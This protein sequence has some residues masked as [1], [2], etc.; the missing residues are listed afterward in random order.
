MIASIELQVIS[1]IL[2]SDSSEDVNT[3]CEFDSSYYS[4]FREHIDYI[5]DH[6]QKY[7]EIPDV[8][9]F[10]AKF[11]DVNLVTVSEPLT[12]LCREMRKNKQHIILLETFNKLK[13]LGSGDV[14]DAWKYIEYQCDKVNQLDDT[15][16]MDIVKD[17]KIRSKEIVEFSKQSRIPT[18]FPE[19]DK[20]MYGGLSTVEELLLIVARTNSGKA[21]PLWSK[22]LTP[23]GWIQMGDIKI[24]D[25]V[26][27][28]NNDNGKVI[29]IFPQGVKDYYRVNFD[30]GTSVECCDDHLWEV[31][32]SNRRMRDYRYYENY[33][34]LTTRE[35]RN[36]IESRYSVDISSAIEFDSD[37]DENSELDGYLL[38]L[39]LGDGGLRDG[40]VVLSNESDEIWS[41]IESI[42]HKYGCERGGKDNFRIVKKSGVVKNVIRDKLREYGL[43]YKKSID[44]FIPSIYL[45]SPVHVRKSLLAGLLDTDGYMPKGSKQCW[46]FSTSSEKLAEDFSELARSL[47]VR[48]TVSDRLPSSY[49][50]NGVVH[51]GN[52][53]RIIVGRSEFNPFR[54]SSKASRYVCRKVPYK[55]SMPKR[56]CKMVQSI[57][58]VGRTECQ[59][60]LLDNDSHTYITDGYTVTHNSWVC[61]KM[62][63]SAQSN[64]FP[65]LYYS[66]EMQAS[67]LGTR[68]D[69]WR[70]HFQN[71]QLH[72]GKYSD[73]YYEY[74]EKLSK[75]PVSAYVL[76]DKNM[77]DGAVNVRGIENLVKK[78]GIKLVIIDGLSYM[79]D[80]H[81]SDT[82]Y[83]KYKNI[84]L[85]L[86]K[87]SKKYGCAIVVAMQANRET[88]DTKDE[89]GDCFP[90][91]YNVEGSDHPAR[92]A[93]QAFALRQVFDKHVLDIR[94]E[95]SRIANNQKP[96]LSYAWDA[97]TGNIRYLPG[98]EDDPVTSVL[99]PIDVKESIAT[100]DHDD[101]RILEEDD[102]EDDDVEF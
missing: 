57:E 68:F 65:V 40:G 91:L 49:T 43:L 24:G 56:H 26:V 82:D 38:G 94:L 50:S 92:I 53:I 45:K 29:D 75:E 8:F 84:C 76:E 20:L 33:L 87:I 54:L 17:A 18:G 93:T 31:L 73:E 9:T 27:G 22:V 96:V 44:K 10:Q 72:Q 70:A 59:C 35:I 100:V 25:V 47:G 81:R 46:E 71:S 41:S 5:L 67:Y 32:D 36:S 86:F 1:K 39:I 16:P 19:I 99:T 101:S 48:V 13:D 6:R 7:G 3:L 23:T 28:K 88:K 12:Y 90:G 55:R 77:S 2:T 34:V 21:Q 69:T 64:G 30:D 51:R 83:I 42:L 61:T 62:M 58:Y 60:I 11:S 89:K 52:G 74:I 15:R 98:D 102:F 37:F 14:T 95:K 80:V 85:D 66:P 97:N 63:E 79:S 78:H 4:V